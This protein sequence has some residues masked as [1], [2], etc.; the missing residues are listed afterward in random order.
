MQ[1]S[2]LSKP[3]TTSMKGIAILLVFISHAG[4]DGFRI[5]FLIPLGAIAVA[6]FLILSGYGLMESYNKN[7][8]CGFWSKRFLRVLFPYLIWIGFYSSLMLLLG[9]DLS[10]EDLRYWFV[11]YI[12]IWYVAFYFVMKYTFRYKWF[13]FLL[14]ATLLFLFMPNLYAQQSLSFIVGIA[15]SEKK[16]YIARFRPEKLFA[17]GCISLI[18]ALIVFGVKHWITIRSTGVPPVDLNDYLLINHIEGNDY[19]TKLLQLAPKV[20]FAIFLI[21][22]L[23]FLHIERYNIILV[24]GLASYES[25]LVQEPFRGTINENIGNLF[26]LIIVICA[27]TFL[28]YQLNKKVSNIAITILVKKGRKNE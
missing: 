13:V 8:L 27:F 17:V 1:T 20:P 7:G 14:V 9:K 3:L 2:L 16:D 12:L 26:L 5:K 22:M 25:Y 19:W 23:K 15:L 18:V 4:N 24:T 28:L 21:I 10:L 11:E 6:V